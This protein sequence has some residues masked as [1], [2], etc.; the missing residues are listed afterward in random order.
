MLLPGAISFALCPLCI[1][2]TSYDKA[3]Y[4]LLA[5]SQKNNCRGNSSAFLSVRRPRA[6]DLRLAPIHVHADSTSRIQ[7]TC[8]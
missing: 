7:Q 4:W 5:E 2:T 8:L 1:T 6:G 3:R